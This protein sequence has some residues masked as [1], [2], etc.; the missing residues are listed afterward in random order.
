MCL[1]HSNW[2]ICSLLSQFCS[3]NFQTFSLLYWGPILIT[4]ERGRLK[5]GK[6]NSPNQREAKGFQ[7]LG[8]SNWTI[9]TLLSQFCRKAEY[10]MFRLLCSHVPSEDL[11]VVSGE[12]S[13]VQVLQFWLASTF[14]C[15]FPRLFP[16]RFYHFSL[17]PIFGSCLPNDHSGQFELS[18]LTHLPTLAIFPHPGSHGKA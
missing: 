13:G 7:C 10:E 2:T 9:C 16:Y 17:S 4:P 6:W 8:H 1:G 5:M 12:V 15:I 11:I 3:P 14:S 18:P